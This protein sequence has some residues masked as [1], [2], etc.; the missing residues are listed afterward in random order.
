M[1]RDETLPVG[2]RRL[3]NRLGVRA[4]IQPG[5]RVIQT[6]T[7]N[8]ILTMLKAALDLW[9]IPYILEE[10]GYIDESQAEELCYLR[11]PV[12]QTALWYYLLESLGPIDAASNPDVKVPLMAVVDKIV[13]GV[14]RRLSSDPDLLALAGQAL[15]GELRDTGWTQENWPKPRH[16]SMLAAATHVARTD[17]LTTNQN[18]LFRLNSFFS[19]ERFRR[20]HV[21]TG[22]VFYHSKADQYFVAASP[23]CDL[24]ARRPSPDQ[25]WLHSIFPFTP[26]V[27]VLLAPSGID[28][29]LAEAANGLHIFLE[30]SADR[31]AFKIVS[32]SGNQPSYE[33][34][35][36]KNEGRV[37]ELVGK[38][39]FEAARLSP[40]VIEEGGVT[41]T[42]LTER[43]WID[44]SFEVVD[45]LRGINATRILQLAGQHLSRIGLDFISTPATGNG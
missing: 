18:T 35:M 2:D 17:G 43:D 37:R 29:A 23:A 36:I 3:N 10:Y 34:L 30:N 1:Q 26:L 45:Q 24:V 40:K 14:R 28:V 7:A 8:R 5:I 27:A 32:G 41:K 15:L 4:D 6:A 13:D 11:D 12:T 16:R 44:D 9:D 33:F 19:T 38:T 22:T 42:S 20:A 25:S 21:T 39:V 31:K